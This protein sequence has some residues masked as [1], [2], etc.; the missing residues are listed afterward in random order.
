M[1]DTI[2]AALARRIALAAQGFGARPSAGPGPGP[3]TRQFNLLLRRLALL[4]IDSVNVYERSHYQPVFARLGHYDKSALDSVTYGKGVTE[5]WAHEASFLPIETLPLMAWRK[6]DYRDRFLAGTAQ[7]GS[8]EAAEASMIPWLRAEL[9]AKGPMRASEIEHDSNRRQGPWWGW[10]EA[11]RGLETM[12]RVG[13]VVSA[14]RVRFE[15]VYALP[16]QVLP[17]SVLGVE[18]PR[19][20]AVRQLMSMSARAHGIGTLKDFAD[21]FR[22]KTVDALPAVLSLVEEGELVPVE[23]EGWSKPAWLH[24]DARRPRRLEAEALLSP[25]DPVVWE[26]SR[27]ERLFDFH[28]RIEIYTPEPKRV[29]GYYTLPVLIDDRLPARID[30]K[31][32]RQ[33]GVLR[34]QSAWAEPGLLP[35][36]VPRIAALLRR[37]AAWQGLPGDIH[38]TGKGTLAPALAA[39]L[40]RA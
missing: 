26:R 34:V 40:A 31:S 10:S 13:D 11:K 5:Y 19:E 33:S 9:A 15:R 6:N 18:V 28:Y 27:T 30:L 7:A 36:D 21:Y 24:R 14:G 8:A 4:Q 17:A 20:E 22:L 12:F 3:G 2:S 1:V 37:A 39:E 38:L 32:D 16:E 25:F 35:D 29:Y 23:V